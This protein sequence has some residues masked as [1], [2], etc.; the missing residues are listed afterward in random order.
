MVLLG[1]DTA[2]PRLGRTDSIILGFLNRD[3]G[4]ASLVSLPRDLYVYQPGVNMD[5]INTAYV[6]GG[7][8]LLLLTLEYN[9]GVRPGHWALVHFDDFV[10]LVDDLGGID[11]PVSEAMPHDCGSIPTGIVNMY[12]EMALCYVRERNT[13]GEFARSRR[14]QEVLRAIFDRLL[15][16]DAL[17][18]LPEWY[19]R[20]SDT[21]QTNWSI[22]DLILLIPV[23]FKLQDA[24][25]YNFQIGWNETTSWQV[26]DNGA[27]VLL[28]RRERL[29]PVIQAA[30]DALQT[31][32]PTSALLETRIA[33]LTATIT[34]A[35]ESVGEE[36]PWPTPESSPSPQD[37]STE[38]PSSNP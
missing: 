5:R 22:A 25:L 26:P 14:Q 2:W 16:I 28:P 36:F 11:V 10:R 23:A 37:Q 3:T 30:I 18:H 4:S 38:T 6:A 33:E 31:P 12:G 19:D 13:T 20:Y 15:S 34:P 29:L 9:F 1:V 35:L 24:A 7:I 17:R 32:L 21:V 8:D 27:S